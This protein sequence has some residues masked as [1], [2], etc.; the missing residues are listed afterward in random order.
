LAHLSDAIR[1]RHRH[2]RSA[3]TQPYPTS[4]IFDIDRAEI[5]LESWSWPFATDRSADI[6]RYFAELQSQR[7]GVWNGRVLLLNR[8]TIAERALCGGCFET[9]YS[10][11]ITWRDRG[12]PD[13][14]VYNFFAAAV[15]RA[16]DGGYLLGE[17]ASY[18]AGAGLS[19]F[20]CGTPEP[21]DVGADGMVD[22]G[23]NL[24]RELLEETGIAIAEL[25]AESGWTV[26]RDRCFLGLMKRLTARQGADELR[27]R[28]MRHIVRDKHSEL[29]DIRIVRGPADIDSSMPPS[30][31]AYLEREWI[32]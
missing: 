4:E 17:M 14:S 12:F 15:L 30:V 1:L 16:A 22:L 9:D 5:A 20:P 27:A 24:C 8:Y 32:R 10:S 3:M 7:S 2:N 19:Y 21:A 13:P 26:V 29:A 18:T 11:F 6:N 25:D 31:A 28:I 23:D